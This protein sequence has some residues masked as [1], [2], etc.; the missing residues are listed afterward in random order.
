MHLVVAPEMRP[1]PPQQRCNA[2]GLQI[3]VEVFPVRHK[4]P[5]RNAP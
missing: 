5:R 1:E 4:Q 2:K 3:I